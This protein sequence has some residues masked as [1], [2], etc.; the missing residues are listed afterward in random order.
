MAVAVYKTIK[1]IMIHLEGVKQDGSKILEN[2]HMKRK[3]MAKVK[4]FKVSLVLC[5][6]G[7]D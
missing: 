2:K 7:R 6:E 5:R 3:G 1:I 4:I